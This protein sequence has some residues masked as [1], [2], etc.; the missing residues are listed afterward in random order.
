MVAKSLS[1]AQSAKGRP[2]ASHY[3][4]SARYQQ[5]NDAERDKDLHHTQ[6][7]RP[8][9][10]ERRVCGSKRRTLRKRNKEIIEKTRMPVIDVVSIALRALDLHLRE[11]ETRAPELML[12]FADRR[13]TTIEP[14]IP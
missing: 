3:P 11:D 14:P 10:K 8:S 6:R 7:F 4:N 5:N 1:R 9:R 2:S 12:A 13:P